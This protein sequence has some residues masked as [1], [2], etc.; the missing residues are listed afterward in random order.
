M[1]LG[2]SLQVRELAQYPKFF[3]LGVSLGVGAILAHWVGRLTGQSL[4]LAAGQL[5]VPVAAATLGTEQHQLAPG[6]ALGAHPGRTADD[7]GH[8]SGQ[9]ARRQPSQTGRVVS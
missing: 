6:G 7:R 4:A 5:G 1:W 9:R 2:P 3:W 8:L